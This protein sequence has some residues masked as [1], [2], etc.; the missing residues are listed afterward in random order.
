[1]L[2]LVIKTLLVLIAP[3]YCLHG[4]SFNSSISF[5]DLQCLVQAGGSFFIP[6]AYTADGAIDP[7]AFSTLHLIQKLGIT[8]DIYM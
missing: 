4:M 5:T 2:F 1:M 8:G 6:R 7:A 3:T